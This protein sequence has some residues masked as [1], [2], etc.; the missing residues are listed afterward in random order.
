MAIVVDQQQLATMRA[1]R[2]PQVRIS[3]HDL[4]RDA[5]RARGR[6]DFDEAE[7][8]LQEAVLVNPDA[9]AVWSMIGGLEDELGSVEVARDAYRHALSLEDDDHVGM[10]LARLH[11]S[12]GEWDDAIAVA[13]HVVMSGHDESLRDAAGRLAQ[14]ARKRKG[15]SS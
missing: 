2:P 10:A 6:G 11:A 8:L 1:A 4:L 13:N 3:V 9:P 12:V 14:E 7:R 5:D 15:M